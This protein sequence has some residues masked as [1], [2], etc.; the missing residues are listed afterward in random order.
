MNGATVILLN[1][2][3]TLSPGLS[4][5]A[6]HMHITCLSIPGEGSNSVAL[7][8]VSSIAD[9]VGNLSHVACAVEY[10]L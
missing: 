5:L 1:L 4:I 6:G 2:S 8:E 9:P 3:L 10:I 7:P